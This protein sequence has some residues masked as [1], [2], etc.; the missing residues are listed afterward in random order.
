[1]MMMNC[2]DDGDGGD[3][4]DCNDDAPDGYM[5]IFQLCLPQAA[6]IQA[7]SCRQ[8]RILYEDE[9]EERGRG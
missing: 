4:D 3:V 7:P 5:K 1:M 6:P 8:V 9:D 2:D